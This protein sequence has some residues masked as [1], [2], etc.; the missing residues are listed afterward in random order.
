ML[1]TFCMVNRTQLTLRNHYFLSFH[2]NKL[3]LNDVFTKKTKP[4][5]NTHIIDIFYLQNQL[6]NP[7]SPIG[8]CFDSETVLSGNRCRLSENVYCLGCNTFLIIFAAT[9]FRG[10]RVI[11]LTTHFP[12]KNNWHKVRSST[13]LLLSNGDEDTP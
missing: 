1:F 6:N 7:C 2:L 10:I 11:F 9:L 8:S 3:I 4:C 13:Q 5:S 12:S